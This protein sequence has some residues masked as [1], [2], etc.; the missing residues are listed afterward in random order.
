MRAAGGE[1]WLL[2]PT[3]RVIADVPAT[4]EAARLLAGPGVL[5]VK[6]KPGDER[7]RKKLEKALHHGVGR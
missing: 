6:A 7:L 3:G 4:A 1:A 5:L 2:S